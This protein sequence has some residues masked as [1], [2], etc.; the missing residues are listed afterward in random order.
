MKGAMIDT[1]PP[2]AVGPGET[3]SAPSTGASFATVSVVEESTG[4]LMLSVALR[5][6][7]TVASSVQV[8]LG[9]SVVAPVLVQVPPGSSPLGVNVHA[10]VNGSFSGSID[11]PTRFELNPSMPSYGPPASTVGGPSMSTCAV[12]T[13]TPRSSSWR[14]VVIV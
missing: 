4:A 3:E 10:V 14:V 9:S 11:V 6:T 8:T 13:L 2:T 1:G 5:E 7:A 12:R